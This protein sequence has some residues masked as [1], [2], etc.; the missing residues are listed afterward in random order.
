MLVPFTPHVILRIICIMLNTYIFPQ[1]ERI[2]ANAHSF[3]AN[4]FGAKSDF[5]AFA[6]TMDPT[7]SEAIAPLFNCVRSSLRTLR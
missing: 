5:A 4:A 1:R 2:L 7:A 6:R 3:R